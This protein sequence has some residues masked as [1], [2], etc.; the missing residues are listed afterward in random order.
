MS[1]GVI[2]HEWAVHLLKGQITRNNVRHAYLFTGP[3]GIGKQTLALGFIRA[4]NCVSPP[5]EGEYCG[6]CRPC[7]LIAKNAFPDMHMV[8]VGENERVIKVDK[9]RALRKNLS[10]SPN[11]ASRRM[12]L[13][14]D[15]HHA[16]EQAANALLKTL[17]EPPPQVVM[18]VTAISKES[19]LP[20]IVSRCEEISL[21]PVSSDT[22]REFLQSEG[23][24]EE[25]SQLL[26]GVARGRPGWAISML[27]DPALLDHRDRYLDE[28]FELIEGDHQIRFR[29]IKEWTTSLRKRFPV[30]DDRRT[31]CLGVLELWL[32]YWRDVLLVAHEVMGP[33]S[34]PDRKNQVE[35]HSNRIPKSQILIAIEAIQ[36]TMDVIDKNAN[37]QLALETLML[38]LPRFEIE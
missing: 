10:L 12:A 30:L 27:H 14:V 8:A 26:A 18:I 20:T 33:R 32:G 9:I 34:N 16:T 25:R 19:L 22:L 37:L 21:R 13:L 5:Q 23:E 36:Q 6:E 11:Q 3:G 15:F 2:G 38:D 31:E 24:N 4:L 28:M 7:Q 29:Y 35:I 1:W 17:E